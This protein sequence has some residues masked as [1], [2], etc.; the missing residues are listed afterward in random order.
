M[1]VYAS[2]ADLESPNPLVT[3]HPLSRQV[4]RHA[5][6]VT[7]ARW[8]STLAPA[9]YYARSWA[10]S[11]GGATLTLRLDPSLRWHDG[12]PTTAHDA[13]FTLALARDPAVGF[14]RAADL[15]S[16]RTVTAADDTTLVLRFAAPQPAL[17]GVLCELPIVPRHLLAGVPRAGLR[18][19]AYERAPVGNGPF[20]FVSRTPN[21]RWVL[22]R[23]PDFPA[24]MGGP[25]RMRRLVVA[26]V[27][28][29]TTKFAG[30][31]SG[32]LD[33]AG[34]APTMAS[35]VAR[36]PALRVLSYPV[37]F[38]TALIF[39]AARAPFDDV[40]VRR[41]FSLALDRRRVVDAA[42]AGYATPAAGAVPPDNPLALDTAAAPAPDAA[43]ADAL[44]DAPG[45]R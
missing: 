21:A 1:A 25:P 8:D 6:L 38:S 14:A 10:W 35:L 16:L 39:N 24:S 36:D 43:V 33:V 5:L 17:P 32:E 45:W 11:D 15:S 23:N 44:L 28:E 13:A 37:T 9:P 3:V 34:I 27:D 29:P 42:L 40:R 20:R 7:L 30:L 4:Q 41:A 18:Q 2:G 22:E 26:V 31:V 19:A 12:V